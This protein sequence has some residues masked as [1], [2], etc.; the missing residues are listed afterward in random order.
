[1]CPLNLDLS[2]FLPLLEEESIAGT[3][4]MTA[5]IFVAAPSASATELKCGAAFPIEKAIFF[6]KLLNIL[7]SLF[8]KKENQMVFTYHQS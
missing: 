5:K 6:G 3:L 1:M 8:L 4:S 7:F 2:I